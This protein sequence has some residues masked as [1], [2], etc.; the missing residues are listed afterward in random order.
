VDVITGL[1]NAKIPCRIAFAVSSQVDSRVILDTQ[2]AEKL[3]GRGDMLY[4]PPEQAKPMRIQGAFVSDREISGLV[5][6]L[7]NQG[8]S[9]QYTA[10][11]ISMA[12]RGRG[13]V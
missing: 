5:S 9:P 8:V 11:V 3:L 2:G 10:E 1:S 13:E 12:K 4:L 6:F 7:K